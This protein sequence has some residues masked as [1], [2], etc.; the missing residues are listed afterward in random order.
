MLAKRII[1]CLDVKEGRNVRGV[2]F[3][4]DR[5]AGDPVE[6][7]TRYDRE[8]ADELVFYDITASSDGRAIVMDL[9]RAVSEQVFIPLTV[10]GGMRSYTDM[11][12]ML[13]GGADKVSIN[14]GAVADPDIIRQGAESFGSQCIVGAIDA[15]RRQA[16]E[17]DEAP[18]WEIYV[19]GGRRATGID[20]LEWVEELVDRGAGELVLNSIDADGTREGYD[21]ALNRAVAERVTVPIVAS[22]GCGTV[23]HIY[24]VL[25]EG[26]ASAALA[27]SVFHFQDYTIPEV[28][29]YLRERGVIVRDYDLASGAEP[30]GAGAR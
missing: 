11:R 10:G 7:A 18:S 22:G 27:A 24:D 5:D 25:T 2:K 14:S 1:P 23:E 4:A 8:G 30:T 28:K 21:L 29:A 13:K 17:A 9:V 19:H 12:E 6:L 20:A 3:S 15:Q 26:Q 16:A